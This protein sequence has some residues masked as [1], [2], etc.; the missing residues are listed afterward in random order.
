MSSVSINCLK[1]LKPQSLTLQ[2]MAECIN[3]GEVRASWQIIKRD[4]KTSSSLFAL[5]PQ[6]IDLACRLEQLF[7]SKIQFEE[8]AKRSRSTSDDVQHI[9]DVQFEAYRSLVN[10]VGE[11][12]I[13]T[14]KYVACCA[15]SESCGL[16]LDLSKKVYRYLMQRYG[17]DLI[18]ARELHQYAA[19]VINHAQTL[20]HYLDRL[21]SRPSSNTAFLPPI[22]KKAVYDFQLLSDWIGEKGPVPKESYTYVLQELEIGI[23]KRRKHESVSLNTV[24]MDQII[25]ELQEEL[26]SRLVDKKINLL[27][28]K[29][30][31]DSYAQE[32]RYKNLEGLRNV[33]IDALNTLAA[34]YCNILSAKM[35]PNQLYAKLY[36]RIGLPPTSQAPI[37]WMKLHVPYYIDELRDVV[38]NELQQS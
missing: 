36:D 33:M 11:K 38:E 10:E 8:T 23:A 28:Q 25:E 14:I 16:L 4:L 5:Y 31:D 6:V 15:Q 13:G 35:S 19:N 20:E 12:V 27:A 24:K 22:F 21:A 30:E 29:A 34:Q 17:E 18:L 37:V 3:V 2:L 7:S 1:Q 32:H 26:G 9:L